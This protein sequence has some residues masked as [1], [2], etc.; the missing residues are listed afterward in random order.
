MI[1]RFLIKEILNIPV[2]VT[3]AVMQLGASKLLVKL[4]FVLNEVKEGTHSF[5]H[6]IHCMPASFQK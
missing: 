5:I 2:L 3:E 6:Q 4:R 1:Y